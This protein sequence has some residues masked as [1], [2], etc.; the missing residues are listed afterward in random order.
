MIHN[1]TRTNEMEEGHFP[2][3]SRDN[4]MLG[5]QICLL[6]GAGRGWGYIERMSY[7]KEILNFKPIAFEMP[8]K[9]AKSYNQ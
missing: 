3:R 1:S 7:G 2:Q 6:R 9:H 5:R 4:W 8:V